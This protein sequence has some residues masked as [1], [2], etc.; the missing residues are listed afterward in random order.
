MA[1]PPSVLDDVKRTIEKSL[2]EN[3]DL[4]NATTAPDEEATTVP[5]LDNT[6]DAANRLALA[7]NSTA[8]D[9]EMCGN[10]VLDIAKGIAAETAALAELLRKHSASITTKV[11]GF[12][13]LTKRIRVAVDAAKNSLDT[14]SLK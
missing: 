12:T 11:E 3:T 5:G 13:A 10:E 9:I 8:S 14:S 2:A 1:R 7:C 6:L 4:D